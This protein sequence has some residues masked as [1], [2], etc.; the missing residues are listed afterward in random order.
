MVQALYDVIVVGAGASGMMAAGRAAMRGQRVLLLEKNARIGAKLG[1]T[2]GGRCNV[3]NAEDDIHVLLAQYGETKDFLH[4][5][6]SQFGVRDA[7]EFF[8]SR[9]INAGS[10]GVSEF[11]FRG[12][13]FGRGSRTLSG[14]PVTKLLGTS[15]VNPD[16]YFYGFCPDSSQPALAVG[17]F[18][19]FYDRFFCY[20]NPYSS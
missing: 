16:A 19:V 3:T 9:G 2:G 12:C 1:I 20:A 18:N 7:F 11:S 13:F 10:F 4:S 15:L 17:Y 5:P 8:Q 14:I 6:F